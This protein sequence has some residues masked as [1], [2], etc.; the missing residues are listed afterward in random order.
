MVHYCFSWTGGWIWTN[1]STNGRRGVISKNFFFL[2]HTPN[3]P[4]MLFWMVP[5]TPKAPVGVRRQEGYVPLIKVHWVSGK[6]SLD[7]THGRCHSRLD[8]C[9]ANY[10]GLPFKSAQMA[11]VEELQAASFKGQ[12]RSGKACPFSLPFTDRPQL[13]ILWLH[14][15]N[16]LLK[17]TGTPFVVFDFLKLPNVIF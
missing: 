8:Y 11:G 15:G 3:L 13:G 4:V 17:P 5:C 16:L 2:L 14:W 7:P 1:F 10:M 9:T 6:L 12:N